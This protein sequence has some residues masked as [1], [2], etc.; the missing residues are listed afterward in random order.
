MSR[1]FK[2][3]TM[4]FGV[5]LS[6]PGSRYVERCYGMHGKSFAGCPHEGSAIELVLVNAQRQLWRVCGSFPERYSYLTDE[7]THDSG[8]R[9]LGWRMADGSMP[10]GEYDGVDPELAQFDFLPLPNVPEFRTFSPGQTP[11]SW[12]DVA[13]RCA[14]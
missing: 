7:T 3:S 14:E 12:S 6:V 5:P 10:L 8:W 1:R 2:S 9:I 13:G 11:G 4:R